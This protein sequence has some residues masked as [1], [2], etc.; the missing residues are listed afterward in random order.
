MPPNGL[1]TLA[2]CRRYA[3]DKSKIFLVHLAL[4][5]GFAE[6][7]TILFCKGHQQYAACVLV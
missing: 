5:K 1:K 2:L 6:R 4:G 3:A 7:Q